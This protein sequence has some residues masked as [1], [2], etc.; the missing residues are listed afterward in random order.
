M[1]TN[2]QVMD[3]LRRVKDPELGRDLVTLGMVRSVDVVDGAV[4]IVVELT[5]P[6]C[7]L[8]AVI[9]KDIDDAVRQVPGVTSVA[10]SSTM[11]AAILLAS[12]TP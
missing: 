6:A 3:A 12:S 10:G 8:K 7:P 1:P 9:G 2:E 4:K 5:T 11:V